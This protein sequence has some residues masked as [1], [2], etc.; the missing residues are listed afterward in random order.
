MK[1]DSKIKTGNNQIM[2]NS[3]KVQKNNNLTITDELIY[4]ILCCNSNS[5]GVSN[6]SRN[7]LAEKSGIKKLDT[8]T[9]HTNKL[10]QLGLIKKTYS[11]QAGKKLAHYRIINPDKDFMWVSNDIMEVMKAYKPGMI[12]FTIK[13]AGLR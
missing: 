6:I 2:K 8:I 3:F 12:G 5:E 10:E 1:M 11:I 4:S 9:A 7:R 13:L